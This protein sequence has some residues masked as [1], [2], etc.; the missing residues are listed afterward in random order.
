[1]VGLKRIFVRDASQVRPCRIAVTALARAQQVVA[2]KYNRLQPVHPWARV[3]NPLPGLGN[4]CRREV[5][6][7]RLALSA[8]RPLDRGRRAKCPAAIRTLTPHLLDI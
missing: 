3:P 6:V 7:Q 8:M 1:M 4:F 5:A 2:R